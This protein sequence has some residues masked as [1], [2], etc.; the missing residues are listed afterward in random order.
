MANGLGFV[1]RLNVA[2]LILSKWICLVMFKRHWAEI[3]SCFVVDQI[4]KTKIGFCLNRWP[5]EC[6]SKNNIFLRKQALTRSPVDPSAL[7][8]VWACFW[9]AH[10]RSTSPWTTCT[11]SEQHVKQGCGQHIRHNTGTN[12]KK[13]R[14]HSDPQK[15]HHKRNA[16]VVMVKQSVQRCLCQCKTMSE[17]K[18]VCFDSAEPDHQACYDCT[19]W[20]LECNLGIALKDNLGIALNEVVLQHTEYTCQ[21]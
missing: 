17:L 7:A 13:N 2:W 5:W 21:R 20:N 14:L 8:C 4:A 10:Q 3:F 9:S 1:F 16:Q 12:M 15:Q 11:R 19:V 6:A 18:C